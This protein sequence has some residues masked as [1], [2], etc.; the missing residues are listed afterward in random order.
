MNLLLEE[1]ENKEFILSALNAYWADALINLPRKDLGDIKRKNY[2]YQ[3][4]KSKE[5]MQ[6][7]DL[8]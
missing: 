8:L 7:I 5:L 1:R 4:D 3:L 6:K 2:K